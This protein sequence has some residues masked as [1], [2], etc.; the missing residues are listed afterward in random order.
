MTEFF[1]YS[2]ID[3]NNL[4]IIVEASDSPLP[5]PIPIIPPANNDQ[6]A[7]YLEAYE[8]MRVTIP[9]A[10]R[11]V[12]ATF[13]GCSFAVV[14]EGLGRV[15]RRSLADPIGQ[16]VP[17]LHTSDIDC[18]DFPHVKSGDIIRGISGP[19]IYNFDQFKIVQ[20]NS[21]AWLSPNHPSHLS[22][23]RQQ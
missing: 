14:N 3:D 15:M 8:S 2:E 13:S 10:A 7:I 22:P 19:L 12:G 23:Y 5:D 4:E 9:G 1:G 17:V 21:Q 20:Q 11:V 16:I 18:D 6:Q